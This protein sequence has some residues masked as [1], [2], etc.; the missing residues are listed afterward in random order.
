MTPGKVSIILSTYNRPKALF[1]VLSC[2]CRQDDDNFEIVVADDGSDAPTSDV[3]KD[4]QAHYPALTIHHVWHEKK[5]F[6]LARIRN[7]AV[8]EAT[9]DYLIFLDGDCVPPPDFIRRHRELSEEGWAVYGQRILA[10]KAYT[11]AVEEDPDPLLSNAYWTFANFF[12]LF[13]KRRV[14][15]AFPAMTIPGDDWRKRKPKRWQKIRGCNWAM[16]RKDY[17]AING[18]DESFEGW[19]AED[20]DVA[21]R[22][23]NYGVRIKNGRNASFVL[24]LWHP[25]ANRERNQF[26]YNV[27]RDRLTKKRFSQKTEFLN[28]IQVNK[29]SFCKILTAYH[30]PSTLLSNNFIV[31]INGGRAIIEQRLSSGDITQKEYDWLCKNTISD[32]TGENISLKNSYYNELSIIYW[33]WHNLHKIDNPEY[34]GLMHYRRH[35]ILNDSQTPKGERWTCDFDNFGCNPNNYLNQIGLTEQNLKSILASYSGIV[36]TY[37]FKKATV[38]DHYKNSPFH[39]IQDLDLCINIIKNN[40]H[41][42]Y[43]ACKVY[44]SGTKQFF[45]N[46]TIL[47]QDIFKEYCKFIFGVLSELEK[48]RDTTDYSAFE[49]RLFVSER[50]TGIFIQY[51]ISKGIRIKEVPISYINETSLDDEIYPAFKVYNIPIVFSIDEHYLPYLAVTIKSIVENSSKHRNYDLLILHNSVT[52]EQQNEFV[53]RIK[54]PNNFCIRFIDVTKFLQNIDVSKFY[55]EI[56][57]TLSTYFRFFIADI[58]KHYDKALYLD[59]DTIVLSDISVLYDSN[60]GNNLIGAVRDV[61][62]GIAAKL[63]MTVSGRNWYRYVTEELGC[64][65]WR[66][67]FQ[68][69]VLLFNLSVQRKEGFSDKLLQKLSEIKNPILSDQDILNSV[70]YNRTT[71]IPIEWN[72]EWQIPLEFSEFN[73]IIPEDIYREY[74]DA[75]NH[76]KL[77]HYASS[78]KPWNRPE[79]PNANYWWQYAR[80]TEYYEV[81]ILKTS[82]LNASHVYQPPVKSKLSRF[83]RKIKRLYHN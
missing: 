13:V 22:L 2:L 24:H 41:K 36:A 68:A 12:S 37:D 47:S 51:L 72:I 21:V 3:V 61:R 73:K 5:G 28:N 50:L 42:Y 17:V 64:R 33:C 29:M 77:I 10:N 76:P 60:I 49:K 78:I 57:V 63:Q 43:A 67:Y 80:L 54:L 30:E 32:A 20:K 14:N 70:C 26:H 4:F 9:G 56:H 65:D 23:I 81:I 74:I 39:H 11:A 48:Q 31:P 19:G 34:I 45:C 62:E 1:V 7:L 79:L 52:K 83:A 6:R 75:L 55:I 35:F 8:K 66:N 27:V 58:L 59:S 46:M 25:I 15:R 40:F 38:Y 71:Y 69:G 44:I 16:W 53:S 82:L 18:S